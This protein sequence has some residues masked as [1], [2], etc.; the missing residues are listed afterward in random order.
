MDLLQAKKQAILSQTTRL[1]KDKSLSQQELVDLRQE[2]ERC[3]HIMRHMIRGPKNPAGRYAVSAAFFMFGAGYYFNQITRTSGFMTKRNL[4][5]MFPCFILSPIVGY[6]LGAWKNGNISETRR[7]TK[8]YEE[9]Q[10]VDEEF[11]SLVKGLRAEDF[12]RNP[13]YPAVKCTLDL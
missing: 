7:L 1:F 13:S 12:A 4:M 2:L 9:S 6:A 11:Y 8:L 3:N 10:E 5:L